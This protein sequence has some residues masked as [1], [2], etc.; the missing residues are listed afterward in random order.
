MILTEHNNSNWY[1]ATYEK[2]TRN[3]DPNKTPSAKPRVARRTVSSKGETFVAGPNSTKRGMEHSQKSE[4]EHGHVQT[5]VHNHL[6]IAKIEHCPM[7]GNIHVHTIQTVGSAKENKWGPTGRDDSGKAMHSHGHHTK[8]V[9]RAIRREVEATGA[10]SVSTSPANHKVKSLF[11]RMGAKKV[12]GTVVVSSKR[13]LRRFLHESFEQ[14]LPPLHEVPYA[15]PNQFE[16]M[17]RNLQWRANVVLT[18]NGHRVS[19]WK[20]TAFD[21]IFEG[22]CD[23]CEGAVRAFKYARKTTLNPLGEALVGQLTVASCSSRPSFRFKPIDKEQ[24]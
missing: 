7:R 15:G 12:G 5:L 4:H 1:D 14:F 24:S 19:R 2:H 23:H 10:K 17:P 16:L 9:L 18:E 13:F 6:A 22:K 3:A 11:M 21:Q 20:A 8:E